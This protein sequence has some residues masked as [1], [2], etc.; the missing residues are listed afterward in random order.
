MII[1]EKKIRKII[2]NLLE[3]SLQD[4]EKKYQEDINKKNFENGWDLL[5]YTINILKSLDNPDPKIY[6]KSNFSLSEKVEEIKKILKNDLGFK[7]IGFGAF[8]EVYTNKDAQFIVKIESPIKDNELMPGTNANEYHK[9]FNH[10]PDNEPKNNLFTKIYSFDEKDSTWII[11]EKVNTFNSNNT[12][13][14]IYDIFYP[15]INLLTNIIDFVLNDPDFINYPHPTFFKP[16]EFCKSFLNKD[17]NFDIFNEITVFIE[18]MVENYNKT[19]DLQENFNKNIIRFISQYFFNVHFSIHVKSPDELNS[20]IKFLK[21][22]L[23]KSNLNIK[24]TPDIAYICKFLKNQPIQDLHLANVGYRNDIYTYNKNKP[25]ES[26][27]ILDFGEYGNAYED[28]QY[29]DEEFDEKMLDYLDNL[30]EDELM[31]ME[32][33]DF[34]FNEIDFEDEDEDK[35]K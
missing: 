10:G 1:T 19:G 2:R 8:R 27:V 31:N 16:S 15:F 14:T 13:I 18:D 21:T 3:S 33:D 20:A 24:I 23:F 5:D 34:D 35:N 22:K 7:P 29:D 26:F 32:D 11:F 17:K 30:S 9:Y 28:D 25:W 6:G 12:N 4:L